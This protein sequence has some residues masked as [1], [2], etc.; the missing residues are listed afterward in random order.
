MAILDASL[1]FSDAQAQAASSAAVTQSTNVRN[2]WDASTSAPNKDAW[3]TA[4][5]VD[6]S[7]LTW[8]INVSTT[9]NASTIITCKLMSHTA[10]SSIKSGTELAQIVLAAAAAAGTRKAVTLPEGT[11][12]G[13][14]HDYV[15][16]TYTVSGAKCTAGAINSWMGLDSEKHD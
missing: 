16:V 5:G 4:L 15:G 3:G 1:E 13:A 2:L 6:L 14:T 7:G 8:N 10:A 11:V 9:I 12:L